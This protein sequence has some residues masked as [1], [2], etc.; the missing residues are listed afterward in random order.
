MRLLLILILSISMIALSQEDSS[1]ENAPGVSQLTVIKVKT[2]YLNVYLDGLEKT[3]VASNQI[4]KEMGKIVDYGVYV[5]N[6]SYVYLTVNYESYAAMD[7]SYWSED[8]TEEFERRFREIISEDDQTATAQSYE[9]IRE[10]VRVE[11][12]NQIV[13]KS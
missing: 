13:F 4:S 12:V 2:N 1:R 3:W 8:E 5:G 11:M 9:D 7:P 6:N 10:I